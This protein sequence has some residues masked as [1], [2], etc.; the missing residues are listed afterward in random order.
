MN[1]SQSYPHLLSMTTGIL[2]AYVR[3]N[4]IQ[5]AEIPG[6]VTSVFRMLQSIDRKQRPQSAPPKMSQQAIAQ[7]ITR[8]FLIS[9]EDGKPY[10]TLRR[11]LAIHG[12]TPDAYRAKWGLE[13]DYP[14]TAPAYSERRSELA[15]ALGLGRRHRR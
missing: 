1:S 6:A 13:E 12:L 11:H 8:D 5:P 10:K 3:Y 15:R 2:S 9:F 14:M 7:S 4:A